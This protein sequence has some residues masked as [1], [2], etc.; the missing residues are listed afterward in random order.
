[1]GRQPHRPWSN[2]PSR[3]ARELVYRRPHS[4]LESAVEFIFKHALLRDV[5]YETVLLRD[6]R[7][8]HLVAA[9]WLTDHAGARAGELTE[10]IAEHYRLAGRLDAAAQLHFLAGERSLRAGRALAAHRSIERAVG[11]WHQEGTE[12]APQALV[13]LA[14]ASCRLGRLDE[15]DALVTPLLESD[16]DDDTMA[17]ALYLAGWVAGDRQGTVVER[18]F[19]DRALPLAERLGGE[20][21]VRVLIGLTW[22]EISSERPAWRNVLATRA[23]ELAR[24]DGEN[25][26]TVPGSVGDGDGAG[27]ERPARRCQRLVPPYPRD[28]PPDRGPRGR[29]RGHSAISASPITSA[30][31]QT[32]RSTNTP[33]PPT[34]T[35]PSWR[36]TPGS[37]SPS[38]RSARRSTSR[39]CC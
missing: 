28:R 16:L 4:S 35:G 1:M 11:L 37:A 20:V 3:S 21:L 30:A 36:S 39:R 34:S 23:I 32:V 29:R 17:W 31:T 38:T 22:S 8:L 26:A 7:A 12:P 24:R 10:M 9:E 25:A 13:C 33:S 19:L 6:R 27:R 15:A 5:A 18:A 14:E 2:S